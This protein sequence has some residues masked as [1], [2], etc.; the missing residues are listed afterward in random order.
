[1]WWC[2]CSLGRVAVEVDMGT[3]AACASYEGIGAAPTQGE[4][5]LAE[6]SMLP[7]QRVCVPYSLFL[8]T[9]FEKGRA[10]R[11][12]GELQLIFSLLIFLLSLFWLN[13][14]IKSVWSCLKLSKTQKGGV[15]NKVCFIIEESNEI[16]K[17][18]VQHRWLFSHFPHSVS[19]SVQRVS[20]KWA[21]WD[22]IRDREQS[23]DSLWNGLTRAHILNGSFLFKKSIIKAYSI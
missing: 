17:D 4:T 11:R 7:I 19:F 12:D 18:M 5:K 1:M 13:K 16:C 3:Q 10:W 6:G 21:N 8:P 22:K 9:S 15:W 20:M 14:Y 23:L 2:I